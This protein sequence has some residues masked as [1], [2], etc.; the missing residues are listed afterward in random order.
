MHLA[1]IALG[2]TSIVAIVAVNQ[3]CVI[4]SRSAS[5]SHCRPFFPAG[6]S[7]CRLREA[8]GKFET[9]RL[10]RFLPGNIKRHDTTNPP[11]ISG[12]NCR[13]IW[14]GQH[15]P[16]PTRHRGAVE[17]Q[18]GGQHIPKRFLP[19]TIPNPLLSS[20]PFFAI[21]RTASNRVDNNIWFTLM[22]S[23][24]LSKIE[25]EN[26]TQLLFNRDPWGWKTSRINKIHLIH[27]IFA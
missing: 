18:C 27:L 1:S 5:D 17:K 3:S 9:P 14:G 19:Y 12:M 6:N 4:S 13:K 10:P 24:C 15:I 23:L 11:S 25:N 2:F 16:T 8:V 22:A 20:G 21:S 7:C 26:W